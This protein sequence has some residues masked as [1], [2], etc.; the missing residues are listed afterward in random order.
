MKGDNIQMLSPFTK[1]DERMLKGM[2][3]YG[4]TTWSNSW[5]N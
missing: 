1:E 2:K 3:E 5:S 4:G